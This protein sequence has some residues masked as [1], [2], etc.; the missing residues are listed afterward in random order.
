MV[1]ADSRVYADPHVWFE[2]EL[3]LQVVDPVVDELV[4]FDP[5]SRADF[6]AGAA[7]YVTDAEAANVSPAPEVESSPKRSP[8][9][10]GC[11]QRSCT[12]GTYAAKKPSPNSSRSAGEPSATSSAKSPIRP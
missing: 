1:D 11:W 3:W 5:E 9:P 7:Q 8:T 10:R 4:R 6:E 2:P 12:N